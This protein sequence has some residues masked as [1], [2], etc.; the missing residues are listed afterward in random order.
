MQTHGL[1]CRGD[2]SS[3]ITCMLLL[4]SNVFCELLRVYVSRL[5][6]DVTVFEGATFFD[7]ALQH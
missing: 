2:A 4:C 7:S 3:D 6:A 1:C 5:Q